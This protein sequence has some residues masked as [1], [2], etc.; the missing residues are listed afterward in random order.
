MNTYAG[1]VQ[2]N[3][4]AVYDRDPHCA[5]CAANRRTFRASSTTTRN[6]VSLLSSDQWIGSATGNR[7]LFV[8]A[9]YVLL[10]ANQSVFSSLGFLPVIDCHRVSLCWLRN[11]CAARA[12]EQILG[13][14]AALSARVTAVWLAPPTGKFPR[15]PLEVK[16][17]E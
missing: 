16:G 17:R 11:G 13:R 14:L 3:H 4:C 7:I 10:N 6:A 2:C 15:A 8:R 12:L 1:Y 5:S 9:G